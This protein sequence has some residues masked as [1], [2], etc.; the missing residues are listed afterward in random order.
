M[1]AHAPAEELGL[2]VPAPPELEALPVLAGLA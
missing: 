2:P 1:T